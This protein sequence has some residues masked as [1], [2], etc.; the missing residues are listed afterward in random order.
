MPLSSVSQQ[1]RHEFR[2]DHLLRFYI[3]TPVTQRDA[4]NMN[5]EQTSNIQLGHPRGMRQCRCKGRGA[6]AADMVPLHCNI[7]LC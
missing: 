6:G 4:V 7:C 1:E 2:T 5:P 3:P